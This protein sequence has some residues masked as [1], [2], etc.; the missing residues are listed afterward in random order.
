[1]ALRA[2][3]QAE[4]DRN[5]QLY[6]QVRPI[7]NFSESQFWRN[8]QLG[9]F[10]ITGGKQNEMASAVIS[11]TQESIRR[12][13]KPV[14]ILDGTGTLEQDL[15]RLYT[16][17]TG[18]RSARTRGRLRV[19]SQ[20][21]RGYDVFGGMDSYIVLRFLQ[22]ATRNRPRGSEIS[23]AYIEAF[24]ETVSRAIP[25]SLEGMLQLAKRTDDEISRI[26]LR[27]GIAQRFIEVL[28]A[29]DQD[30]RNF[31]S[32]LA[33]MRNAFSNIWAKGIVAGNNITAD[34]ERGGIIYINAQSSNPALFNKYFSTVL[35]HISNSRYMLFDVVLY[36][37]TL[38]QNDGLLDHVENAMRRSNETV[39]ICYSN[40]ASLIHQYPFICN[41]P[42]QIVYASN[43]NMVPSELL[44]SYGSYPFHFPKKSFQ[45]GIN[46][47]ILTF[48]WD[49]GIT[50]KDR[51]APPDFNEDHLYRRRI[52]RIMKGH[53]G[54]EIV[55]V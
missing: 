25:L 35:D 39:G 41:M 22:D 29:P 51:I 36:G 45:K 38:H 54:A 42:R 24:L 44:S 47:G 43:I 2:A 34:T 23:P 16:S 40:M 10:L 53:N 46:L 50:S 4:C 3:V 26:A 20:S 9:D 12:Q 27:I 21:Y 49:I 32:F 8:G 48:D 7:P 17:N 1:M 19:Y 18:N 11:F 6:R 15:I 5:N 52:R 37:V 13:L 28:N 30:S 55:I 33:E 14:I 31:R